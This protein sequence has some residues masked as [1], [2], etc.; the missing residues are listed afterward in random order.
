MEDF[1]LLSLAVTSASASNSSTDDEKSDVH[2]YL[3]SIN[4][5]L[6]KWLTKPGRARHM[7]VAVYGK[8][9]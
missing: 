9:G 8:G 3:K 2:D 6:T 7:G 4:L 5:N 1:D